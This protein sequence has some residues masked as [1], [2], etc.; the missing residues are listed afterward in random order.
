MDKGTLRN[1]NLSNEQINNLYNGLFVY[2][3]GIKNTF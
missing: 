3:S 2:T 1:S